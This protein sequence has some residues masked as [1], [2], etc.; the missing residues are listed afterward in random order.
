MKLQLLY[1]NSIWPDEYYKIQ[2]ILDNFNYK[3]NNEIIFMSKKI[4]RF[5]NNGKIL[6]GF[7]KTIMS[8]QKGNIY[9]Y[10]IEEK[11]FYLNLISIK[12]NT[13]KLKKKY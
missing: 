8:D 6:F 11:I 4:T 2:I 3:N 7:K 1:Q 10:S 5:K 9:V 13:K 12:N